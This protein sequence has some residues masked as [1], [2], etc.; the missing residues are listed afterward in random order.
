FKRSLFKNTQGTLANPNYIIFRGTNEISGNTF[1]ATPLESQPGFMQ[2]DGGQLIV[3]DGVTTIENNENLSTDGKF[4]ITKNRSDNAP[5]MFRVAE[6]AKLSIKNNILRRANADTTFIKLE[7]TNSTNEILGDLEVAN[8]KVYNCTSSNNSGVL[9]AVHT[10]ENTVTLGTGSIVVS[11]N[12]A[13]SN[14]GTTLV[15]DT[16]Y[17]NH[18]MYQVYSALTDNKTP[19]FTLA[20]GKKYSA[21][22]SMSV[23][24]PVDT[25]EGLGVIIATWNNT[26]ATDINS[27]KNIFSADTFGRDKALNIVKDKDKI[28]VGLKTT[29]TVS[30]MYN[31]TTYT[32]IA[33]QSVAPNGLVTKVASPSDPQGAGRKFLGWATKSNATKN[34]VVD[35]TTYQITENT[36]F[37]AVFGRADI[38]VG[39]TIYFGTYPQSSTDY[40]VVD[41]IKWRVLKVEDGKALLLAHKILD[42]KSFNDSDSPT[43]WENSTLR[44]WT[45]NIFY[46]KA[47]SDDEKTLIEE[48]TNTDPDNTKDKVFLLSLNEVRELFSDYPDAPASGTI[49]AKNVDNFGSKLYI[50]TNTFSKWWLRSSHNNNNARVVSETGSP[51]WDGFGR[52]IID[53][54]VGVRPT[55]YLDLD[56]ELYNATSY[57]ITWDLNGRELLDESTWTDMTTYREGYIQT[58][59]TKDNFKDGSNFL[60]WQINGSDKFYTE[61]PATMTGDITLKAYFG[62]DYKVEF[63]YDATTYTTIATQNVVANGKV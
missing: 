7:D 38:K 29:F 59:P 47:F 50:Y 57:G 8:N 45:N 33:T 23:A 5:S 1:G 6:G 16:T 44:N 40:N 24:F 31:A 51:A 60:G 55:L 20:K 14:T 39:D 56:A 52:S 36:K 58:L 10:G 3:E 30:F 32:S 49:Y 54:T 62:N 13:Y 28:V 43:S 35:L 37:F 61:I 17:N 42:N 63:M 27:Y 15:N 46:D 22:S 2:I 9:V 41:P 26:T 11:G 18:H 34:D 12:L 48:V 25:A 19:M 21:I 53:R 4:I